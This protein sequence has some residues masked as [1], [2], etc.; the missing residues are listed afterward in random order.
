LGGERKS[1]RIAAAIVRARDIEAI[2]T[3]TQLAQIVK[4]AVGRYNDT[5]HPAT[6]TFQAIRIYVNDELNQLSEGLLA[7]SNCVAVGG[8][9]LVVT[10]HSL[11]DK[12]VKDLF[13]KL[14]GKEANVNRYMPSFENKQAPNFE[15]IVRGVLTPSIQEINQNP[16][17]RSAKLRAIRRVK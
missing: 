15:F 1:R 7:A 10:F 13:N 11:E 12:I 6:R 17:A 4:D 14:C 9:I 2:E 16:R 5:I 8:K 3:T